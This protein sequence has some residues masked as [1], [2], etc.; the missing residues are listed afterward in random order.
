VGITKTG[1]ALG[2]FLEPAA[3]KRISAKVGSQALQR[4]YALKLGILSA[5]DL[6]HASLAQPL[7]DQEATGNG[8]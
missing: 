3:I 1:N 4:N 7:A 8:P 2:F 5:I 6:S